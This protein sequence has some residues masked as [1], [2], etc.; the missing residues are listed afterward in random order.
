MED[1]EGLGRTSD[2]RAGGASSCVPY[3][4]LLAGSPDVTTVATMDGVYRHVVGPC[5]DVFGWDPAELQGRQS[6]EFVHPDDV[7]LSSSGLAESPATK[8]VASTFRFLRR[9][10]AYRWVESRTR[11][12]EL[13]GTVF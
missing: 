11:L 6:D 3:Q 7:V 10:G 9:D 4:V 12:V 5:R 8:P 1:L 2:R 13:D